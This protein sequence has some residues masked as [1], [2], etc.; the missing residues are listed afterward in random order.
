M[1][2]DVVRPQ[3]TYQNGF[4]SF[5]VTEIAFFYGRLGCEKEFVAAVSAAANQYLAPSP[6]CR[7]VVVR[8]GL[9]TPTTVV[10]SVEWDSLS[11]H[12][13][14]RASERLTLWRGAISEFFDQPPFVEH[15]V[16]H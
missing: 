9:E 1:R 10:V 12:E 15:Y 5:P 7:S 4:M 14:F 13:D 6:G 2:P 8:Q 3:V 16:V 11:A